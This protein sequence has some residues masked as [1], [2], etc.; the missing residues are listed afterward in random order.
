MIPSL[1]LNRYLTLFI[2]TDMT[3]KTSS[4]YGSAIREGFAYL[5]EKYP[6]VFVIGQGLWSPWYVGNSMTDLDKEFGI[7]RII[8]TPVAE[9]ACTGAAVGAALAGMKPIMVHPRMDFMLY[10]M[11]AIVNQAAKWSSMMGGQAHAG[12]TIRAI[13]NRGGEQGAQHSQALH[14]WFAHIP[15]LRVVMPYSVS[16]ARDLLIASVLSGDPVIYID[17]RWLY[18]NEEELE[19]VSE[20]DLKTQG[21]KIIKSGDDLTLVSAG[22]STQLALEA[23]KILSAQGI[24]AEVIDMRVLSPIS[25][26]AIIQSV[27]KTGRLVAVDG[28]WSPAGFAG[29]I[30]ATITEGV[31]PRLLKSSPRRVTLPFAPAPSAPALEKI[32]YPTPEDVVKVSL[33]TFSD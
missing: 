22:Y 14:A 33:A 2:K 16:D 7:E 1:N 23:S 28:G 21:P 10:A 20:L 9:S 17:D 5:L 30:I 13:I 29:E 19:P 26:K 3:K 27:A 18:A 6:E 12:V 4:N 8:D 31:S 24:E 15:G 32:Y 25:P 11:D